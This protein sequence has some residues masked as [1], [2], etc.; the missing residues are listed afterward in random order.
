M[1]IFFSEYNTNYNTYTFSYAI[2]CVKE[3]QQ[4][5][6]EIYAKGFLP[7]TGNYS[8]AADV[9]YLARSLRVELDRFDD[10]S[11]N[12]R[13]N[14]KM[15]ELAP[16]LTLTAKADFD[17][18]DAEFREF[19]SQYA[20]ERFSGGHMDAERLAYVLSRGVL[21]HIFSFRLADKQ[22]LGYVFVA[23]EGEAL[24]YWF[25]FFDVKYL[26]SHSAG[27]WMMWRVIRWAKDNGLKYCYLGTCYKEK[28]LYKVRDH[29]GTA[30]FD[31]TGWNTDVELLK[32]LC[33]SDGEPRESDLCKNGMIQMPI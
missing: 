1:K 24:H 3:Q 19:C 8:L 32:T 25:S 10:S 26:Q 12:R 11:E 20:E 5:L 31:G 27:K 6:P 17:L 21:T 28:A 2:Y 13:V 18:E 16:E 14:R 22:P 7:Y 23:I 33:K 30:F 4:E 15:E 29:K 9:F